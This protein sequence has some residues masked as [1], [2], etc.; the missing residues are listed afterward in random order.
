MRNV[1]FVIG[2]FSSYLIGNG[3]KK[4]YKTIDGGVTCSIF[5]CGSKMKTFNQIS[6]NLTP[7]FLFIRPVSI[8]K[9]IHHKL[10]PLKIRN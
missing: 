3:I 8:K 6:Q 10:I 7:H 4:I 5:M 1:K 9:L 2:L